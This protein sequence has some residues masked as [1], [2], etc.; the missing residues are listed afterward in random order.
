MST[1]LILIA[2]SQGVGIIKL[3]RPKAL[4]ALSA[5]LIEQLLGSVKS[6]DEDSE[7]GAI[8]ITGNERVFAAGA[9]IKELEKLTFV[10]A[11]MGNFL[12]SLADGIAAARKPILAAVNGYALGGGCELAMMCDVIYAGNNAVFGQPEIKIGTIPGA[13]GTQRLIRAIGKAKAMHMV[14][15]GESMKADEAEQAGLVAKVVS[16]EKTLE[17]AIAAGAAMASMSRPVLLMAKESVNRAEDLA[18]SEGL[19]FERRLYHASFS[20]NDSKEG[21]R[22]FI[23][24]RKPTF[25]H[26]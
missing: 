1:D 2:K 8:V 7:V 14:L 5:A 11:Y 20:T 17:V 21:M 12:Q 25:E 23:Q 10:N 19:R 26:A 15:T 22:A 9:D 16:P 18:L 6:F 13:G 4:N 24:K 3:N